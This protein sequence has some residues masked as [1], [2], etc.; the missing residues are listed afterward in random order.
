MWLRY[1][2]GLAA[3]DELS[4]TTGVNR[5]RRSDGADEVRAALSGNWENHRFG[6]MYGGFYRY[7]QDA[8]SNE[9]DFDDRHEWVGV[10]RALSYFGSFT[11]G[12]EGSVQVL[13][14]NGLN[15]RNDTQ[16]VAT[17]SQLALIPALTFGDK[18]GN[19]TRPQLQ[20]IVAYSH[21]NAA[22][23]N[24]FADDDPRSQKAEASIWVSS[25]VVVWTKWRLLMMLL[26]PLLVLLSGCI[27]VDLDM[28]HKTR[29]DDW[30][31]EIIYQV[32]VDRFEDGDPSNNYNVDYR[33]EA[34]YH[35]GDWQGL[36][37]RLDY[38]EDLGVTALW[39]SPVV[40]NV[41]SDA[42]FA[43]YHGYWTQDFMKTNPHFET[44][45]NYRGS[46]VNAT[47]EISRLFWTLSQT[48]SANCS[49]MTSIAMDNPMKCFMVEAAL[50]RALKWVV[51]ATKVQ[52]YIAS[53]NGIPSSI[54][55]G[56]KGFTSLGENGIAPLVWVNDPENMRTPAP[57][58]G[59]P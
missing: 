23:M 37:D 17:V 46:F 19:Y 38:I 40:R 25:G 53:V 31:D 18:P 51:Q 5:D 7:F 43:S 6:L 15:P 47:L 28:A 36:I 44:L 30:R 11:P 4:P 2:N 59:I 49:T 21:S 52:T 12:I 29:V 41:E 48:M 32:V 9:S 42:G 1:A 39:I 34:A 56:C 50:R 22:A 24:L 55:G 57:T 8:D 58:G 10:A 27:T 16:E 3:F 54:I 26:F 33:R 45:P 20:G 14:P 13:R 35:G